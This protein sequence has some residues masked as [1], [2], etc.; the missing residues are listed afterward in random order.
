MRSPLHNRSRSPGDKIPSTQ[1]GFPFRRLQDQD[2]S[3]MQSLGAIR[4]AYQ[5]TLSVDTAKLYI[6]ERS[7]QKIWKVRNDIPIIPYSLI[8]ASASHRKKGIEGDIST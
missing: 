4:V 7:L 1:K 5:E 6:H 2:L 3:L 8:H